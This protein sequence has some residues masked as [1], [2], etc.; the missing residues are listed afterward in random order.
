MSNEVINIYGNQQPQKTTTTEMVTTRQA[1]EVQA[2]MI[3]AKRFP[4]DEVE[5]FNRILRACQRKSLAEQSMYE[6]PRGGQKVTGPSIR[7]AEALAQN[8]GNIDYGIIELEQKNEESQVMA[9]A[10]DLETNTRQTKIFTVPHI[11][12]S[13][14]KGNTKLT[15]PRDVYEMVA[16]QGARRLRACILGV[17]PG[18]VID[19]AIE[20]CEL[21]LKSNNTEPLIDRVRKMVKAFEDKFA[22]TKEMIEEFIGC[23]SEVFSENDFIRL[24]K[25]YRSLKDNMAKRED[26]FNIKSKEKSA[27]ENIEVKNEEKKDS[28]KETAEKIQEDIFKGS[29]FEG[30]EN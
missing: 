24:R 23:S 4:R 20:Q 3:I 30:S 26:Y 29:P 9:Y 22:I 14:K 13:K 7:L 21:T 25:V 17:I 15:D 12:Y 28:Q 5:S 11:R 16:N 8:W 18:D 19:S 6:Y 1:Q 2:A 27:F 10:W